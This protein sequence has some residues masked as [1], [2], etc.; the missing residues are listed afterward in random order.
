MNL[1]E[2]ITQVNSLIKDN[3]LMTAGSGTAII[4]GAL[5]YFR[6]IPGRVF[7]FIWDRVTLTFDINTRHAMY[8]DIL[9]ILN[10]NKINFLSRAFSIRY[11]YDDEKKYEIVL[12]YGTAWCWY[13]GSLLRVSKSRA[14]GT[15]AEIEDQIHITLFTRNHDKIAR[16]ISDAQTLDAGETIKVYFVDSGY[17]NACIHA[18]RRDLD[19]VFVNGNT[20]DKLVKRI[21]DFIDN[22]KWY[23]ERGIPYKLCIMLHGIAGTGKTSLIRGI[24]SKF[25]RDLRF[26]SSLVKIGYLCR[27]LGKKDLIVIEDIDVMEKLEERTQKDVV[28]EPTEDPDIVKLT[29][30]PAGKD[31]VSS[32]V[33]LQE[34]LNTLDGF[35]TPHGAIFIITT[36]RPEALDAAL[37][38]KGRVDE[39]IEIGPLDFETMDD[40]F[41]KFYGEGIQYTV[42][43]LGQGVMHLEWVSKEAYKPKTGA[44]LQEIFLTCTAEEAIER[45]KK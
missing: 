35:N 33:K 28:S 10:K 17:W 11:G 39:M 40:M 21:Q 5:A 23:V 1:Q 8:G 42:E 43:T 7:D 34:V 13:K 4:F 16:L 38:R 9:V 37:T 20:K 30:I 27:D 32:L 36:N 18:R 3:P 12:G 29:P 26:I 2:A 19:T 24:A 41:R 44:E 22:E 31:P 15:T 25:D 6:A 14:D 45:L